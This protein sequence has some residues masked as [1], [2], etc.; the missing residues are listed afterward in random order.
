[1]YRKRLKHQEHIRRKKRKPDN[2]DEESFFEEKGETINRL[3]KNVGKRLHRK[4]TLKEEL[5][6]I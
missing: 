2:Y 3:K 6:G 1:M 5:L 4:K